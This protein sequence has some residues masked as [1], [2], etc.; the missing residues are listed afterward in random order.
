MTKLKE[1]YTNQ[2]SA[3]QTEQQR[4]KKKLSLLATLRL[5][6]FVTIWF[7]IYLFWDTTVLVVVLPLLIVSFLY[8][9]VR[10]SNVKRHKKYLE[11][12]IDI[13]NKE[14]QILNRR[15]HDFPDGSEFLELGHPYAQDLDLFGRGS[16]Y[17]YANRTTL[18]QGREV[19]SNLLLDG[20]PKDIAKKQEAIQELVKLPEWRQH[21]SAL[22]G[23]TQPKISPEVVSDWMKNHKSFMPKWAGVVPPIFA[24]LSIL[25]ITLAAMGI[26]PES[27]VLFWYF[28]GVGV[29]GRYAKNIVGFT[30]KVSEAQETIQQHQ[31]LI[32][33][34]EEHTLNSEL[35]QELQKKLVV[36]GEKTSKILKR[37]SQSMTMLEQQFNLIVSFFGQGLG[38]YSLFYAYQVES[39]IAKYGTEVESWFSAIAQFDAYITL[40]TYAFNHPDHTYPNLVQGETVLKAKEVGHPLVDPEKNVLN[41]FEIGKGRFCIVTG[42]NMA[43]KSTFLRAIALQI[44][45]ANMGLP[46]LGKDVK[47]A[48]VRLLTS[49]RSSDSLADETS[50]FYA[51]LKRLKYIVEELEK[52][53][54]F[55]VLDEILKGTNSVDKAEGSKKFVERLVRNG[56]TGMVATHDLS[57]CTLADQLPEVENRYFDAQIVNG[58][59]FFDYRFKEGVCQNMNASFLLKN[60]GIVD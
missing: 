11:R 36:K 19:F 38:L 40:G 1:F 34:L 22:A 8:L 15:F 45:M 30:T 26:V 21:F 58:E 14:L 39:W 47:Y 23:E 9:V 10:F 57:L 3:Y 7:T 56:S 27:L 4:E 54:C 37:F 5:T 28:L 60:M 55:V 25:A 41:D 46:V 2:K 49:M 32:S 18:Q 29:V 48:P 53:D 43:G 20:Y 42:A 13:N 59:L 31:R 51:E 33:E 17:Q 35:L 44:V 52:D 50:Y 16:F 12:L 6:I 24:L